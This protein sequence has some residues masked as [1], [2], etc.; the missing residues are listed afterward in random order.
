ME[1]TGQLYLTTDLSFM[2]GVNKYKSKITNKKILV[3]QQAMQF[4]VL[5]ALIK[6]EDCCSRLVSIVLAV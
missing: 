2:I 4:F 6:K 1:N 3:V 5:F